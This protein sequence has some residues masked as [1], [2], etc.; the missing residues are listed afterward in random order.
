M[1]AA[2]AAGLLILLLAGCFDDG[3]AHQ[4]PDCGP[5]SPPHLFEFHKREADRDATARLAAETGWI[6][7]TNSTAYKPNSRTFVD[8]WV[9]EADCP[10]AVQ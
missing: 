6:N 9:A 5:T 1:K 4:I 7:I 8:G 3:K 10:E 2:L